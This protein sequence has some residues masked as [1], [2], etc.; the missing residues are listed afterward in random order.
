MKS[1]F[2]LPV[3]TIILCSAA[4]GVPK[5]KP[6]KQSGN[7]EQTIMRIEKEMLDGTLKGDPA[8]HERYIVDTFIATLPDGLVQ[9]KTQ[10]IGDLKTGALKLQSATLDDAKVRLYGDTAVITY[11]SADK[12][13]YKGKDITGT[14]RWTDVF[15]RRKGQWTLVST[16]G[17]P[18][19]QQ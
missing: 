19:T 4:L 11:T 8:P 9:D 2:L 6:N 3:V 5:D 7:A 17:S 14:T 10:F 1:T 13:T 16:H 15:V 18:V 12:G